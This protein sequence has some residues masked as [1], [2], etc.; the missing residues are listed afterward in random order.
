MSS[1]EYHLTVD[2]PEAAEVTV[3]NQLDQFSHEASCRGQIRQEVVTHRD[4]I[5]RV[6][7]ALEQCQ[8]S[9]TETRTAERPMEITVWCPNP[10]YS[11]S[12]RP[13]R[14]MSYQLRPIY[15][16]SNDGPATQFSRPLVLSHIELW[17]KLQEPAAMDKVAE[18]EMPLIAFGVPATFNLEGFSEEA[19]GIVDLRQVTMSGG[20]SLPPTPIKSDSELFTAV[21]T[22]IEV[23]ERA[24]G[25]R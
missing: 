21:D 24:C 14:T 16:Q 15:T 19:P 8:P 9:D 13:D 18:T 20:H 11:H 22:S 1:A 23:V 17:G 7:R 2:M 10:R 5:A 4:Y 6:H 25:M 12:Q 3:N